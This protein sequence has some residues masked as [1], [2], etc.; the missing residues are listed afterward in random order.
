MFYR[1]MFTCKSNQIFSI[2]RFTTKSTDKVKKISKSKLLERKWENVTKFKLS[3]ILRA[4]QQTMKT[5]LYLPLSLS[6]DDRPLDFSRELFD[7][8]LSFSCLDLDF[9]RVRLD[10]DRLDLDLDLLLD[11]DFDLLLRSLDRDLLERDDDRLLDLCL[12]RE[13]LDR[14]LDLLER[15]RRPLD[16]DLERLELRLSFESI[17][18]TGSMAA[19]IKLWA[20]LT[21]DIASSIS[22]WAA[23]LLLACGL[24]MACVACIILMGLPLISLPCNLKA[25]MMLGCSENSIKTWLVLSD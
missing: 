8:C 23:S 1:I 5:S 3:I 14:D 22:F 7:R 10:L 24:T 11:R 13:R 21:R 16:L 17:P 18:I 25:S 6:L 4:F 9:E 15:R 12:E 20:S 2:L 19:D